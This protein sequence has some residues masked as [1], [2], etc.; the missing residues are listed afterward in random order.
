MS[1]RINKTVMLLV[2]LDFADQKSRVQDQVRQ[3][4]RQ[5]RSIPKTTF[6]SKRQLRMIQP[7]P[8]ATASAARHTP[9][10]RNVI[11]ARRRLVMRMRGFYRSHGLHGFV[12]IL[13][14]RKIY[15]C[16]SA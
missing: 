15:P 1:D 11:V 9:S 5:K 14:Q 12:R 16:E 3:R 2:A 13:N 8:T 4:L 7:N 10:D 6:T